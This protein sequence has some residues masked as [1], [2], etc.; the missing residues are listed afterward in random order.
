MTAD[1]SNPSAT[2]NRRSLIQG[3]SSAAL[4]AAVPSPLIAAAS[5]QKTKAF[6]AHFLW[7]CATAGAQVEGNNTASDLWALEH[8]PNS[9]YREPSGDACDHYHLF[10]QDIA[11]LADLGFNT[12]RFSIEWSRIEPEEGQFSNAELEHYRRV[13]SA[14]REH[15][16]NTMVTYSHFAMP[17]WFAK[18]GAWTNPSAPDLF[19]RFCERATKHLGAQIDIATTFNEPNIPQLLDWINLAGV[20]GSLAEMFQ[21]SLAAAR[22]SLHAPDFA[23][24][25]VADPRKTRDG[26]LA[27]HSKGRSAIKSVRPDLPVGINLSMGDDQPAP[28]DSHLSEKRAEVYGPWFAAANKSDFIGVQMY[29]RAIVGKK[30]LPAPQN[31]ELTQMGYEFYPECVEGV[32]RYTAREVHVPI[33]VTENGVATD[34]DTRRV[35]YYRRALIGL[36]RTLDD[37]IDVRGYITWS[38]LD[39]WEWNFGYMPKFGIVAVD[40][41]TQQRTIKPSAAYL[42][43]IARRNSL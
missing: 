41:A 24:F 10:A 32:I 7:G 12:Y 28:S 38:L 18:K 3:I 8:I 15:H 17:L 22:D 4:L 26:L 11:M 21:K 42:G 34:D 6:P 40:R 43:N 13:L 37:G 5:P 14:C 20:D 33:Y 25:F 2:L 23:S 31:S 36:K 16:L 19:A 30:D 27:A 1:R 29:T 35:E 39:N 9:M